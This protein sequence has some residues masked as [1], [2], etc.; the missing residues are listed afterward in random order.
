[1]AVLLSCHHIRLQ[2]ASSS[3]TCDDRSA[4]GTFNV[5]TMHWFY[6]SYLIIKINFCMRRSG[7]MLSCSVTCATRC[8]A[9]F[10]LT[11]STPYD[12]GLQ[13]R[14]LGSKNPLPLPQL[15]RHSWLPLTKQFHLLLLGG[16]SAALG[17]AHCKD[18]PCFVPRPHNPTR[19]VVLNVNSMTACCFI[20]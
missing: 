3:I 12:K 16:C 1:M 4:L 11:R 15:Q 14:P 17:C 10:L 9:Y 7:T 8:Q 19:Q 2:L 6:E 18:C 20:E 13:P 5:Q